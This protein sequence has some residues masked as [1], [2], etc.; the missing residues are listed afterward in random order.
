[1]HARGVCVKV[2]KN[3]VD[4]YD[5]VHKVQMQKRMMIDSKP[6]LHLA[7]TLGNRHGNLGRFKFGCVCNYIIFSQKLAAYSIFTVRIRR[8]PPIPYRRVLE[9]SEPARYRGIRGLTYICIYSCIPSDL[10][11]LPTTYQNPPH[12]RLAGCESYSI[13]TLYTGEGL[14]QFI[15]R[16]SSLDYSSILYCVLVGRYAVQ[17]SP[18]LILNFA[19]RIGANQIHVCM[20]IGHAV[21][22]KRLYT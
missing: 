14:R 3:V 19:T 10:P 20:Y 21:S 18:H 7:Y 9:E 12:V 22:Q 13:C 4:K 8:S 11:R 16:I 5:M 1:M 17:E 15:S 6:Y 2:S